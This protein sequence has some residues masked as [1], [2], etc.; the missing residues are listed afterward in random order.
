MRGTVPS[1]L[2]LAVDKMRQLPPRLISALVCQNATLLQGV[3]A[4]NVPDLSPL[5]RPLKKAHRTKQ[6]QEKKQKKTW[7]GAS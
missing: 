4:E 7:E 2:W 5:T 6:K 1:S 3:S